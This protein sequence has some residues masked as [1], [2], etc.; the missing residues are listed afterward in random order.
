M[1]GFFFVNSFYH[2]NFFLN[3]FK[4]T[5]IIIHINT[6]IL[7]SV[8][9]WTDPSV[10]EKQISYFPNEQ[11]YYLT[12]YINQNVQRFLLKTTPVIAFCS[13]KKQDYRG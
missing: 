1:L 13:L 11:T 10:Y 4:D 6:K 7:D 9:V 8:T 2:T 12:I 5:F 3:V